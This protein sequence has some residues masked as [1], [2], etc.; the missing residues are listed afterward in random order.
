VTR[1]LPG[2]PP[3][4]LV[5]L[6]LMKRLTLA[7]ALLAACGGDDDGDDGDPDVPEDILEFLDTIPGMTA[8]E[9]SIDPGSGYRFFRL[10]Y[11][12]PA[13]H[14]DPDGLMFSQRMTLL[15]ADAGAPTILHTSG[16]YAYDQAFAAEL[17]SLLS[18]NQLHVEQRFF[19][20]SRPDPADWSLLTI[21][22]AAADHHRISEALAPYYTG[23]WLNT[24]ASKGG[25]TSVYHRRFY[26][27]D[28]VATVAYVAPIS[29]GAPDTSYAPFFEAVDT[30]GCRAALRDYQVEMLARREEMVTRMAALPL[31]F[32][33]SAGAEGA[34][35]DSVVEFPWGFWQYGD[36]SW[37][38]AI[39]ASDA[40]DGELW[41]FHVAIGQLDF[42]GDAELE[43]YIPYFYQA[44][45]ELGFPDIPTGHIDAQLTTQELER[46][47]MPAGVTASYDPSAMADIDDWVQSEG[48]RL[49]FIY[50]QNDPWTEGAFELGGAADSLLLVAP[51][52]NHGASIADLEP[53]DQSTALDALERWTGV[54][55]A[56]LAARRRALPAEPAPLRLRPRR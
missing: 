14:D 25:M 19:Q 40:S 45:T 11:E 53:G 18:G 12:Q 15:H 7:L 29:H 26:P 38:D 34:F 20:P 36:S 10:E 46:D 56:T 49:L 47:Y 1:T 4:S 6:W 44:E 37:C 55:P 8:T 9:E 3:R 31:T 52:M 54:A 23:P 28:V 51:G 43:R 50:G 30:E 16:Y 2:A 5:A 48:E 21:A 24:G 32:E 27:D 41:D 17:T 42:Y 33:R 22:Q 35:E 39:P 13:D